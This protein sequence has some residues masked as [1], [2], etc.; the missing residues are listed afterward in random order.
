MPS[1]ISSGSGVFTPVVLFLEAEHFA[2][3]AVGKR[4][5]EAFERARD[6]RIRRPFLQEF[7]SRLVGGDGV[8]GRVEDLEAEPVGGQTAVDDLAE[9][10]GVT[11]IVKNASGRARKFEGL[12]EASGVLS[13]SLP[14]AEQRALPVRLNGLR[15]EVDLQSGHKTG[16]YLDQQLNQELVAGYAR[17]ARVLDAFSFMGGFA[18]AA[19]RASEQ[20]W[21]QGA[22]LSPCDGLIATIK[23]NIM[24]AGFPNRRGSATTDPAPVGE[25][26]PEQ[27]AARFAE[28]SDRTGEIVPEMGAAQGMI[29]LTKA[30]AAHKG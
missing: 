29:E 24:L 7:G 9:V 27:V 13:G 8:V 15:F 4:R 16:L 25:D 20:R 23:D 12:P 11:A 30:Q 5:L 6:R 3:R 14:D 21:A 1:P 10:A 2:D 22:P 18:L 28:I 17:D 26:A 19:A